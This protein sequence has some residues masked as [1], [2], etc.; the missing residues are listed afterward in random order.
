MVVFDYVSAQLATDLC[1]AI[2][3]DLSAKLTYLQQE[4]KEHYP[5][6]IVTHTGSHL[7]VHGQI[8]EIVDLY[9]VLGVWFSTRDRSKQQE[10][11]VIH[12]QA[13]TETG[14]TTNLPATSPLAPAF[15]IQYV[16]QQTP[17]TLSTAALQQFN[18]ATP[19]IT[20]SASSQILAAVGTAISA[21]TVTA[22]HFVPPTSVEAGTCT[23]PDHNTSFCSSTDDVNDDDAHNIKSFIKSWNNRRKNQEVSLN[24][25]FPFKLLILES[26][27]NSICLRDIISSGVR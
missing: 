9:N 3:G 24:S 25:Y 15:N 18:A 26:K 14:L 10:A 22:Q 13:L 11:V 17:V 19:N 8:Q 4:L 27:Y 7:K 5:H 12:S 20:S 2:P 1:H 21:D 23:E 16:N 6:V